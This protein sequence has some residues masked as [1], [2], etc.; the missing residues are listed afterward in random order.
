MKRTTTKTSIKAKK[1]NKTRKTARKS[2]SAKIPTVPILYEDKD[3]VVVNKPAGLV[4]HSDGKTVEPLLTDWILKHYP[5][6]AKVGEPLIIRSKKNAQA[7]T[8]KATGVPDATTPLAD[9]SAESVAGIKGLVEDDEDATT[10]EPIAAVSIA[11]PG[12][13]HR[14]DRGTS[15]AIVIAKNQKAHIHLKEQ[16]Q[17]HTVNKK[18][19]AFVYGEF[20]DPADKY[21]IID[22]P[23]GRSKRDFRRW[24]AQRGARGELRPAET[25]YSVLA[26][27]KALDDGTGRRSGNGFAYLELEP[28]TGRTHQIRVHLKA[29]NHP[30]VCDDLYAPERPCALGFGRTALHAHSIE[31]TGLNGKVIKVTAPIPA[32]FKKAAQELEIEL[33]K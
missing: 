18:Y 4:V 9:T 15:G 13:V 30:V 11:R 10:S 20:A 8:M 24:S 22:R 23:I 2:S 12:I 17:A 14:L 25:W 31:F 19:V 7:S 6:T 33:G 32:D 21:G 27:R 1:I 26:S 29:I 28:K 5:K 16:F 3:Y